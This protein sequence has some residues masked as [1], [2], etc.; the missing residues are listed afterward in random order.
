VTIFFYIR[1]ALFGW[2]PCPAGKSICGQ[3]GAGFQKMIAAE[4]VIM[5][6]GNEVKKILR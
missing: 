5:D 1:K 2:I 4:N 3:G 6:I